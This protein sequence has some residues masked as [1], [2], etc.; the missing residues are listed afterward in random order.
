M[1]EDDTN[2]TAS[3][4]G[5]DL[6]KALE[7][8]NARTSQNNA[9]P[10]RRSCPCCVRNGAPDVRSPASQEGGRV[11]SPA[12]AGIVTHDMTGMGIHE[13]VRLLHVM[14]SERVES[15]DMFE[16]GFLQFLEE[17][18]APRYE[19][20]C[21]Q[22]TAE[23]A[24][25]SG[26]VNAIEGALASAGAS[27]ISKQVRTLQDLEKRK[28]SATVELQLV[29]REQRVAELRATVDEPGADG[30]NVA[31]KHAECA[32]LRAGIAEL[33]SGIND[34]MDEIQCELAELSDSDD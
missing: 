31:E 15:Y 14:Q 34:A 16:S 1:P 10:H 33:V 11:P 2:R 7:L 6:A 18:S 23:F 27:A 19:E 21:A 22:V 25:I 20:I 26:A 9:G 12:A 13:L 28:L 30:T 5:I 29:R 32:T 8:L 4:A 24:H 17:L 3:T